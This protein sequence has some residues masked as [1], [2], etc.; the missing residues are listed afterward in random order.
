MGIF[1]RDKSSKSSKQRLDPFEQFDDSISDKNFF[2]DFSGARMANISTAQ[3]DS[4]RLNLSH[5]EKNSKTAIEKSIRH[6]FFAKRATGQY[7]AILVLAGVA[8]FTTSKTKVWSYLGSPEL[9]YAY[10]E[11]RAL[12]PNGR[13]IAGAIVKNAGKRVGT[14]DSFGEWRRYMRVPLGATV[15]VTLAKKSANEVLYATKNFAV[16]PEKPEKSE[17]ELRSSVQLLAAEL[18][19]NLAQTAAQASPNDMMQ[20]NPTANGKKEMATLLPS[21]REET[22]MPIAKPTAVSHPVASINQ[23]V[24]NL[25]NDHE[26]VWFETNG[27]A[28]S[29]LNKEVLPALVQR[30]REIGLRVDPNSSWKVRLTSLVDKP[31]KI[32]K[33]GGGLVMVSSVDGELNGR[34]REFLRNYQTDTRATARGILF[35]LANH[36]NKNVTVLRRGDRWVAALP[37]ATAEIWRLEANMTLVGSQSSFVLTRE[38][39]SDEKAKG[40]YLR[41]GTAEP[42]ARNLTSCTLKTRSFVENAPVPNW[43][44]LRLKTTLSLKEPM[45]IFVSGYEAQP[46]GDKLFEY[47]GLDKTKANVTVIH[48]GRIVSRL[49]VLGDANSPALLG[50]VNISRR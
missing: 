23:S 31:S 18:S 9:V 27:P 15:P 6:G 48:N 3:S 46:V 28:S 19:N 40:F 2:A 21:D 5:S 1:R 32:S 42:C 34:V 50:A 22:T 45:K 43:S 24:E 25:V 39:Y 8:G 13:P 44:R 41:A 26:S 16:P 49:Q 33:D 29:V 47:W 17:I 37:K 11:V 14:T 20:S 35:V 38:E 7:V 30:S 4:K 36:V 12:D 10:F